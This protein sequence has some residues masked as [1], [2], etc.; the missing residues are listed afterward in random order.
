LHKHALNGNM[1]NCLLATLKSAVSP[2]CKE[3]ILAEAFGRGQETLLATE[4][5]HWRRTENR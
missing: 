3:E 4:C 2:A 5:S 1:T